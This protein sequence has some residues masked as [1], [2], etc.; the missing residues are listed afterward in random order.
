MGH[1]ASPEDEDVSPRAQKSHWL[2][3]RMELVE[4]EPLE[5]PANATPDSALPS[6][7][8]GTLGGRAMPE[9]GSAVPTKE[10]VAPTQNTS[11]A[12][13]ARAPQYPQKARRI[14]GP[15]EGTVLHSCV[16]PS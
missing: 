9:E 16:E 1:D 10:S 5:Y 4:H 15:F 7:V 6:E 2:P 14:A 12:S 13:N 3:L 11:A 8:H